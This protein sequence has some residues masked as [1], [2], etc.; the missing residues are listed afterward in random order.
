RAR[1]GLYCHAR[2]EGFADPHAQGNVRHP[3]RARTPRLRSYWLR[4]CVSRRSD[5]RPHEGHGPAD[6]RAHGLADGC[7]ESRTPGHAESALHVCGIRRSVPPTVRVCAGLRAGRGETGERRRE[8]GEQER[9]LFLPSPLSLLPRH[10]AIENGV[11]FVS[12]S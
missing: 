2:T 6:L 7:A 8:K 11:K 9:S 12:R 10:F 5:L 4:R 3:T 1:Q